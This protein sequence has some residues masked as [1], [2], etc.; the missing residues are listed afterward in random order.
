MAA[1]VVIVER[2]P[3]RDWPS[4]SLRFPLSVESEP[5][6]TEGLHC[7]EFGS[8]DSHG[9]SRQVFDLQSLCRYIPHLVAQSAS[10]LFPTPIDHQGPPFC[11]A[12]TQGDPNDLLRDR[13]R[14][15]HFLPAYHLPGTKHWTAALTQRQHNAC[16]LFSNIA[17]PSSSKTYSGQLSLN[18]RTCPRAPG[19]D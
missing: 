13:Y 3:G 8:R 17:T 2:H 14:C 11:L 9:L 12:F 15:P 5:A 19:G 6:H 1:V 7:D 16:S 10:R 4:V 18:V